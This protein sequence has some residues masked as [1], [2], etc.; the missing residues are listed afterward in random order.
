MKNWENNVRRVSPYV[1]GEQPKDKNII[2][3]NTNENPYP[4]SKGVIKIL[5]EYNADS[6]RLYPDPSS[7]ELVNALADRY[8]VDPS[9]IFVGVGSDDVISMAFMTFFNSDK[10]IIFPDITYS[11]YDVWADVYNIPFERKPLDNNFRINE[12][13]YLCENGGI[14]FP[15]PNAP[16]GVYE[17]LD[18]IEKIISYN[19]DVIVMIDEAYIDFGGESCIPLLKKYDNLLIVQT[20]SKSRSLA[21]ARIGFAIGNKKLIS[22]LNDVKFS[23]NSYTIN[24]I[25][26]QIGIEAVKDES[27][28]KE[29]TNRIIE[30]RERTKA[31]LKKL[32]FI[33]P[34][35]KSNFIFASH[36]EKPAKAI[37]EELKKRR[38]Y[39]RY[40]DKPR[41]NNFIRITIG[42]D[43]EMEKLIY[44]LES[45]LIG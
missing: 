45:I 39:V 8:G 29:T 26:Q 15:N 25:T 5:K 16:T 10:P 19:S 14:I 33:F 32:G 44:A 2:K 20:F 28:F 24:S 22:Y 12:K 43:K 35:S 7:E 27:Y 3:L 4:P 40:W 31:N 17:S 30:T 6:L 36:K 21:G 13:D 18:K 11:F 41:I 9:Q 23:V 34:D 38:I 42:T 1:P 37:Y